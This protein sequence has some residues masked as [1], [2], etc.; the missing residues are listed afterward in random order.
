MTTTAPTTDPS[1]DPGAPAPSGLPA[2][3]GAALLDTARALGPFLAERARVH[4]LDGTFVAEGFE[5][6]R[7]SGYLASPVPVELGGGGA[8]TEEVA[9]AQCE[10]ARHC[11]STALASTMHLHVVLTTA[12]RWRRGLPGAEGTLR[13]VAGGVVVASTGGGDFT[14]PTGDARRVDGGYEVSARKAF[15]SG[16]PAAA[17]ASTW[18]VTDDGEAI[19]FGVPLAD[20]AV[21]LVETWDA[22]GMRGTASHDLVLDRLFVPD[23]QVTAR[24]AT[25]EFAP[26][27]AILAAKALTVIAATYLGVAVG[28]RDE[29]VTR[30]HGTAR[31][32]DPGVRRSVGLMDHH[33]RSARWTLDAALRELGEDPE[34]SPET[35]VAGTIVKRAV[36]EHARAVG[37]LAMDVLGGRGYRRGDPVERAWRDLRAGPFHPL[38]H[39]LT[40]RVAGDHALGRALGLR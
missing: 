16:A 23:E 34:P 21:T 31:A 15:V 36:I 35:F 30:T 11:G 39:E 6:L 18:A 1:T 25:G 37:D 9:W 24:R 22:P 13:K 20:P 2:V 10:L 33:L 7:A 8:T 3:P 27:L 28:A 5:R 32:D 26:V 12:W 4:D 29:V 40:L 14:V 19:G 38:D 17:V